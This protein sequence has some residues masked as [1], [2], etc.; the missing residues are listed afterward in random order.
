LTQGSA[1]VT[2]L[3]TSELNKVGIGDPINGLGIPQGT[4]IISKASTSAVMSQ[5]ATIS[6]TVTRTGTL[7]STGTGMTVSSASGLLVGMTVSGPNVP[8]GVT[9]TAISG[10]TLTLSIAYNPNSRGSAVTKTAFV[11]KMPAGPFSEERWDLNDSSGIQVGDLVG[12][13]AGITTNTPH[14][15]GVYTNTKVLSIVSGPS[16][17]LTKV[18]TLQGGVTITAIF[19]QP[20]SFSSA[21]Y[22]FVASNRFTVRADKPLPFGSFPGVGGFYQ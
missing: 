12:N 8:N 18:S 14:G 22:T 13:S 16:I 5:A 10:T 7:D 20:V 11:V 2:D 4:T 1:T 6:N 17:Y 9:I 19:W 15:T 3:S 21:T